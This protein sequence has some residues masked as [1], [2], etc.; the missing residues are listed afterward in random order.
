LIK[1]LGRD[2]TTVL[3]FENSLDESDMGIECPICLN[4]LG[5]DNCSIAKCG[6]KACTDCWS[7]VL[8]TDPRCPIC[9]EA[10]GESVI[11]LSATGPRRVKP[12]KIPEIQG[13]AFGSKVACLLETL[14]AIQIQEPTAKI[15]VFCQFEELKVKITM[16]FKKLAVPHLKL[17]GSTAD[18]SQTVRNF[19]SPEGPATLLASMAVSPS[20]LDL[21][22]AN[23]IIIVQPTWH[24][25]RHDKSVDFEA[26][27]IGRCWRM[28][29][30]RPV[31][32]YRLCMV[33]TVEEAL[34]DRHLQLWSSK[35]GALQQ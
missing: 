33:N 15:L 27:A 18:R 4:H 28:G 22:M 25:D 2:Y 11:S 19:I 21:S 9:R 34:V 10:V 12:S 8:R 5:R 30:E 6:H 26:Q 1:A 17:E 16:A 35:F 32:V 7:K 13:T 24:G 31:F 23:H 3:F 14:S 29:Q 20:G